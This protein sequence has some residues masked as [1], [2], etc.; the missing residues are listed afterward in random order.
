MMDHR[1]IILD[2]IETVRKDYWKTHPSLRSRSE[3]NGFSDYGPIGAK[4]KS[5][6]HVLDGTVI[7]IPCVTNRTWTHEVPKSAKGDGKRMSVTLRAF[8]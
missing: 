6:Y 1:D 7:V 5:I 4:G 2:R 3:R 8:G